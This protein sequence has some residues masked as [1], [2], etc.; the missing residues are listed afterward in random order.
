MKKYFILIILFILQFKALFAANYV[1][2]WNRNQ[3]CEGLDFKNKNITKIY[4]TNKE[5]YIIESGRKYY[6]TD[7][8]DGCL[9]L[10][11]EKDDAIKLL[12]DNCKFLIGDACVDLDSDS[13]ENWQYEC[14]N[15][16]C[17]R[18]DIFTEYSDPDIE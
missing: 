18:L 14:S 12:P 5:K 13:Y 1:N 16:G 6:I 7:N 2:D 3:K 9:D 15:N 17:I 8:Y 4:I 10:K 11:I